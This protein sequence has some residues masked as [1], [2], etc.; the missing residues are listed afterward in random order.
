MDQIVR[1]AQESP[2]PDPS[3]ALEDVYA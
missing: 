3:E 2:T 1:F